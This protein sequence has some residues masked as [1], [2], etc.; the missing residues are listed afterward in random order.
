MILL[1]LF[2]FLAGLVTVLSPCI[3]PILPI[4]LTSSI[5][6]KSGR[7]S[8]PFGV[9]LGFILSFTFFTLFL[10]IIVKLIGVSADSLRLI[11]IF[12]IGIFG[13]SLLVPQFQLLIETLFSKLTGLVPRSNNNPG[14]IGGLAIGLSVGLLWTPCVGPILASVISLAIIGTVTLD[15]IVITL[16]Y[17]AGTAV[18][19]FFI[20]LGGQNA[21]KSVPWLVSNL[22]KIQKIFG[23]V[24]ILTAIGIFYDVDRRFQTYI[25][26]TFPGYGASLTKFENIKIIKKQLQFLD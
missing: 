20:I 6:D 11:S 26:N 10:S 21:L 22:F 13:F 7:M 24:M 4:I 9:V 5:S 18:P 3:L 8:R 19:M 25:L 16:A 15:S 12:V 23:L 1:I 14:F 2:S 17:A